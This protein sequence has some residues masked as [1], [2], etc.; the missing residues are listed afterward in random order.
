MDYSYIAYTKDK[1]LVKGTLSAASETAAT[2]LLSYGGLQ[3]L[4]LKQVVPFFDREKLTIRTSRVKPTELVMFSRQLALLLESGTDIVT[5]LELL[6]AQ[7]TNNSLKRVIGEVVSD[8]RGGSSLSAALRKHPKVFSQLYHRAISAG[9]QGGNLEEV[10]RQMANHIER[11]AITE[12]KIKG[13]LTYPLIVTIVAIVV[14]AML[15]TFVLPSFTELYASL[16]TELP[17]PARMLIGIT[18]WFSHYGLYL[19]LGVAGVFGAMFA[20]TR[21]ATGMYQWHRRLL[22]MPIIGRINLLNQLARCCRTMSL[23]FRVGVP[24][25]EIMAV[26]IYGTTNRVMI[27]ALTEVKDEMLRG[28]G[29]SRPMAR[30][31][32]FLPLMV[33]MI[34]VGEETGN[35]DKTLA[36]VAQSF[37][38]EA[39]DKTSAAVGLIQPLMTMFIGGIVGFIALALISAMY[40]VYGQVSF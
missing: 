8:I 32:L 30:R 27:E 38:A 37:E 6:Q 11:A 18:D 21:T 39:E 20:Y 7:T 23:L 31:K 12:K 36:T 28:E 33:Q 15:V 19:G 29:L 1:R 25:T 16:G 9:E 5:S 4:T 40:S 14:I 35:L 26:A 10:L 3:V 2:D 34:G 17:L 22:T 24:L 13:A